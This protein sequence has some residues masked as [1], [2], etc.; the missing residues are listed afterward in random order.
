LPKATLPS[1]RTW[2]RAPSTREASHL[3]AEFVLRDGREF[4]GGRPAEERRRAGFGRYL[5]VGGAAPTGALGA[6]G[7]VQVGIPSAAG[8]KLLQDRRLL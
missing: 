6:R 4:F 2:S 1:P 7:S 3:P 8:L 5:V